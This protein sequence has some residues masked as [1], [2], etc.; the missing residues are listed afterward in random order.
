MAQESRVELLEKLQSYNFAAY[1][2]LLYLDT[3]ANDK[4][5][6][7]LYKELVEKTKLLKKEYESCFG[8]LTPY[9]AAASDY[10]NWLNSPW[11]WEKEANS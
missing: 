11:P 2:M 5:A 8:P 3:H 1:D 6:F 4:K 7:E 10:F 9:S